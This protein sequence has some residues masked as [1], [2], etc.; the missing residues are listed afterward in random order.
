MFKT[1][2]RHAS[3]MLINKFYNIK[4]F[5]ILNPTHQQLA[6]CPGANHSTTM[7]YDLLNPSLE[8]NFVLP[9]IGSSVECGSFV[10]YKLESEKDGIKVHVGRLLS[11]CSNSGDSA[12]AAVIIN[13]FPPIEESEIKGL[14]NKIGDTWVRYVNELVQSTATDIVPEANV[15]NIAFVFTYQKIL[16]DGMP[17]QGMENFF[18]VRY[19]SDDTPVSELCSFPSEYP[20]YRKVSCTAITVWKDINRISASLRSVFSRVTEKLGHY[21]YQYLKTNVSPECWTFISYLATTGGHPGPVNNVSRRLILHLH[22]L[23]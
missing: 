20:L 23:T 18:V 4:R 19:R 22:H 5:K 10:M 15:Q 7:G 3:A 12:R 11:C 17:F 21:S 2:L 16:T 13:R 14:H 6:Q 9:S 1:C 8:E